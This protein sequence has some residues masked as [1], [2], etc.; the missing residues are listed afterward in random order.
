MTLTP[1]QKKEIL[2][3]V[4][5]D[6]CS[7][8]GGKNLQ[9]ICQT[10]KPKLTQ[11]QY[12]SN[13]MFGEIIV[14]FFNTLDYADTAISIYNA[15]RKD[16]P[17]PQPQQVYNTVIQELNINIGSKDSDIDKDELLKVITLA[18]QKTN[19]NG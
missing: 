13:M 3:E 1:E 9:K 4:F 14:L 12:G 16:T 10:E 15:L 6:D 18:I 17:K 8:V 7:I 11:N 2:L 5:P 19:S